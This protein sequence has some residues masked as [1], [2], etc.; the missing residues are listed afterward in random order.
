M[1]YKSQWLGGLVTL[2]LCKCV[3]KGQPCNGGAIY[4]AENPVE[5]LAYALGKTGNGDRVRVRATSCSEDTGIAAIA[6]QQPSWVMGGG[7]HSSGVQAAV[8]PGSPSLLQRCAAPLQPGA[9]A[10]NPLTARVGPDRYSPAVKDQ[11]LLTCQGH[12]SMQATEG[13]VQQPCLLCWSTSTCTPHTGTIA[14]ATAR[15]H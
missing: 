14:S 4:T 8:A 5:I 6:L 12:T 3:L 9:V 13:E 1:Q 7:Q 11:N 15:L 10:R 2:P